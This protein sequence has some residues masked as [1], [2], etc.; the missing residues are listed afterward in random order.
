[1]TISTTVIIDSLEDYVLDIKPYHSKLSDVIIEYEFFDDVKV[2]LNEKHQFQI[3][4]NSIWGD[5]YVSGPAYAVTKYPLRS[6]FSAPTFF[7]FLNFFDGSDFDNQTFSQLGI[8]TFNTRFRKDFKLLKKNG[9]PQLEGHDFFQSHGIYSFDILD[10]QKIVQTSN[11]NS[12]SLLDVSDASPLFDT[13]HDANVGFI[14]VVLHSG[15]GRTGA[16]H[17]VYDGNQD[18]I[19]R[20]L[21]ND[22]TLTISAFDANNFLS[23]PKVGGTEPGIEL[24]VN[25]DT[26]FSPFDVGQTVF[27]LTDWINP[28]QTIPL[29][30]FKIVNFQT[31]EFID[32][33]NI[34]IRSISGLRPTFNISVTNKPLMIATN[35]LDFDV[36]FLKFKIETTP[37]FSHFVNNSNYRNFSFSIKPKRKLLVAPSAPKETWSLVKI[38]PISYSRPKM[39]L[40]NVAD[41][42]ILN[43]WVGT[44][45]Q[46]WTATALN[47]T[48]FNIVGSIS[49][50]CGVIF[51]NGA[52]WDVIDSS[53]Q[54]H[55]DAVIQL[56]TGSSPYSPIPGDFYTFS[57][58]NPNAFTP[59]FNLV[60]GYDLVEYDA[61]YYD[62]RFQHYNVNDL[63]FQMSADIP[64]S[65]IEIKAKSNLLFSVDVYDKQQYFVGNKIRIGDPLPD[66]IVGVHYS[67]RFINFTIAQPSHPSDPQ[68]FVEN[69]LFFIEVE[70][71]PPIISQPPYFNSVNMP[72]VHL[73]GTSYVDVPPK[74]WI[75]TAQADGRTFNVNSFPQSSFSSPNLIADVAYDNSECHLTFYP[76]LTIPIAA[77][78]S[79]EFD[80]FENQPSYKVIGSMTG[81]TSP[82]EIGKWY[83]NG[84][85]AFILDKPKAVVTSSY[86]TPLGLM[87]SQFKNS[88]DT[89][90]KLDADRAIRFN[91]YP[92]SD[93]A[94]DVYIFKYNASINSFSVI[95]SSGTKTGIDF[96][97][98]Y[99]WT[100]RHQNSVLSQNS[101]YDVKH[102]DGN[103][104]LT[105]LKTFNNHNVIYPDGYTFK[106][107]INAHKFPLYHSVHSTLFAK[108]SNTDKL[109]FIDFSEDKISI[110]VDPD[111]P[112]MP[113]IGGKPAISHLLALDNV[114]DTNSS[115]FPHPGIGPILTGGTKRNELGIIPVRRQEYADVGTLNVDLFAAAKPDLKIAEVRQKSS[116]QKPIIQFNSAFI[117][118]YVGPQ[119]SRFGIKIEQGQLMNTV[120]STRI[121]DA[122]KFAEH[123]KFD[124]F[125]RVSVLDEIQFKI[126]FKWHDFYDAVSAHIADSNIPELYNY[127]GYD[128][129]EYDNEANDVN[130][131]IG[132]PQDSDNDGIIDP[133]DPNYDSDESRYDWNIRYAKQGMGVWGTEEITK[134]TVLDP[135]PTQSRVSSQVSDAFVLYSMNLPS[136]FD[137]A[138]FDEVGLDSGVSATAIAQLG[139][140]TDVSNDPTS[141]LYNRTINLF[142]LQHT[143]TNAAIS[144]PIGKN[145]LNNGAISDILISSAVINHNI[146]AIN[147]I[148]VV[149]NLTDLNAIST[150]I[151]ILNTRS[152][153]VTPI[154]PRT[155]V[156]IIV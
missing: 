150:E 107:A 52:A 136:L 92:R 152:F 27:T 147:N 31:N 47:S 65:I 94:N 115:W 96:A 85:I 68:H 38:N 8:K 49:G 3:L 104:S 75:F 64:N 89:T 72:F 78:D 40:S 123:F 14:S 95:S 155:F 16:L 81:E 12:S 131:K 97:T 5:S 133:N 109:Q 137:D 90:I 69:D 144:P 153:K 74:K 127:G 146:P 17:I 101:S 138:N 67:S 11:R 18:G 156:V 125:A 44:P 62:T 4:L 126:S 37:L 51:A 61:P 122:I 19:H 55:F 22:G 13:V 33:V 143:F 128:T 24:A 26:D 154:S 103:L 28:V 100:D 23:I 98:E 102:A 58:D 106:V 29:T 93:A 1:M 63:N 9:I 124:E 79:F 134:P 118:T 130:F 46:Q 59:Q 111:S 110:N 77:G 39:R 142:G 84:K 140:M 50:H 117:N 99:E 87:Y 36:T 120:A 108:I 66:A 82:A 148:I 86:D 114:E 60:F 91:R 15:H 116:N 113:V 135:R 56:P 71:P 20:F 35:E 25:I 2:K 121:T 141:P 45:S 10:N 57:I 70:N 32:N 42:E 54:K 151:V 30:I 119:G 129:L 132:G 88:P 73:Y 7:N 53:G 21:L 6:S 112:Y 34:N 83:N 48:T 145:V 105:I 139:N 41:L 76:S 149:D 80:I 43:M